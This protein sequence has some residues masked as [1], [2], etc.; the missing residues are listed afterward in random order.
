VSQQRRE[1]AVRLALGARRPAICAMVL[2][3]AGTQ[4]MVGLGVGLAAT[5]A[6]SRLL[7]D[8]LWQTS[9]HDL[10]SMIATVVLVTVVAVTACMVPTRR[11]MDVEPMSALRLD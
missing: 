7:A 4:L 11:A 3:W 8:Q 5:F 10:P 1:I 2:R 6:T 9:P